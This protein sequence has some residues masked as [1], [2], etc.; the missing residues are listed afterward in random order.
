MHVIS[1]FTAKH[2]FLC[3]LLAAVAITGCGKKIDP[4]AAI[5]Q[6]PEEPVRPVRSTVASVSNQAEVIYLPGDVRARHEQ[7]LGF[8]VGGKL[9]TRS[10][11]VGDVV[12]AGQLLATLDSQDAMPQINAQTAQ[13]DAARANTR[14]QS[15][16][17]A[18][19][20]A[21]RD[22]GFISAAGL[23]R[24]SIGAEAAAAQERAAMAGLANARNALAFQSLRADRAGVVIAVDAEVSS[25]LA[26]GQSV[27]RIAQLGEK[28]I[29]VNVP[30]R[31][32]AAVRAS[33]SYVAVVDAIGDTP[34]AL[35]L[36]ELSPAAD[37]L[38]RTYTARFAL[39]DPEDRIKL[40][41]TANVRA[42]IGIAPGMVVPLTA[43]NTRDGKPRVWIV[44]PTSQTVQPVAVT[45]GALAQDGI[46][47][48]SGIAP[49]QRVVT[50][51][52]N[53]LIAGQR[54]RVLDAATSSEMPQSAPQVSTAPAPQSVQK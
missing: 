52:A 11:D 43:V 12:K 21:L 8:R 6:K 19:Q 29:V 2:Y 23:E 37:P 50:A 7:R 45:I 17:L 41:M 9:A 39:S 28:E 47:I 25:V 13:V 27:V 24:Q 10:V 4:A 20:Q 35:K 16:E 40:G 51:G 5:S 36:R 42:E 31:T 30:E 18:R 38:S 1:P 26:A 22:K 34:Y 32:L 44:D 54:V 3:V 46:I 48:Q 49:G 15:S 14:L 33:K 53:L